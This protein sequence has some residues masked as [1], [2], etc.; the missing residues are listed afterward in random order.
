[1][2]RFGL[3]SSCILFA[4]L[5]AVRFA[6]APA[7]MGSLTRQH[8]ALLLSS[9]GVLLA[10]AGA[11][12]LDRLFRRIYLD[13]YLRRRLGRETPALIEGLI[14]IALLA[15]GASVGLFFEAG[16][17]FTGL[18]T[19]SGATAVVLGLALQEAIK[20][21]FGGLSLNIDGSIIIGDWLSIHSEQLE[22]AVHGRVQGITWR[23]TVLVLTDGRRLV[24][25]N[26]VM[27]THPVINH[28]R[29]SGPKRLFVEM[30]V[31]N[32]YPA[33]RA[34]SVLLGEAFR[35][36]RHKP[37]AHRPEPD[38]IIDRFDSTSTFLH[39]RFYSDPDKIDPHDARGLMSKYLHSAMLRHKI[40]TPVSRIDIGPA[41]DHVSHMATETRDALSHAA[42]FKDVLDSEQLDLL[43]AACKT[44]HF[45][46][47]TVFIHQGQTETSLFVILEGAAQVS[48]RMPDGEVRDVAVLAGGDV[49]GE[50]SLMTGAPRAATVTSLT[51]VRV[52]EVTKESIEPL[53]AEEPELLEAFGNVLATRQLGLSEVFKTVH[54][55]QELE[56]DILSQ[57]RQ[58]FSRAFH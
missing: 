25:P 27:T 37:L 53:L 51:P 11:L 36:A 32:S 22:E 55:K 28:S 56:R 18:I 2:K 3:V 41:H 10:T 14:T 58:F 49:V 52:L 29:P 8:G 57:M 23:S 48:I 31:A 35:A 1:M 45:H 39:V 38:V 9:L 15:T 5:A 34:A 24:I 13:G 54:Q 46:P 17:P 21:V 44:R 50:M 43:A 40:P 19:A 26:H 42:I 12:V 33:E 20:D 7:I 30:P 47:H 16:V 6:G 4:L